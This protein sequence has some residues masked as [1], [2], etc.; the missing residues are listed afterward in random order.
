MSFRGMGGDYLGKE[1]SIL[2]LIFFSDLLQDSID[3]FLCSCYN[4]AV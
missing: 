1:V 2:F 3:I 4:T